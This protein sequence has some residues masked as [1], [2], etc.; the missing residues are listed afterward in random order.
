MVGGESLTYSYTP[1]DQTSVKGSSRM[2][3]R[4]LLEGLNRGLGGSADG[5]LSLLIGPGYSVDTGWRLGLRGSKSYRV[6]DSRRESSIAFSASVSLTGSYHVALQGMNPLGDRHTLRYGVAVGSLPTRLYGLDYAT[7]RQNIAS[8]YT[9]KRYEARVGY[10]Y[11]VTTH[12]SLGAELDYAYIGSVK[13]DERTTELLDKELLDYS[14]GS[15]TIGL[16]YDNRRYEEYRT[17]GIRLN[18]SGLLRPSVVSNYN[19]TLYTLR[20]QLDYYQPL[21]RGAT[22][23]LDLYGEHNASATPWMLRARLGDDNRMRGYYYGRY[24]GCN[25]LTAQLELRQHIWNGLGVAAWGGGGVAFDRV[26]RGL[27]RQLLPTYGVGLR[28]GLGARNMVRFDVAF[29]NDSHT[30]ILGVSEAF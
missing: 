21:W 24:M 18:V 28:W 6:G 2:F 29:G 30:F 7:A 23:A 15:L 10:S 1:I 8:K 27:L 20:L 16:N 14:G 26:E 3:G 9:E 12:L 25:L 19:H 22:L 11:A 5:S 4:R 17:R 13:L